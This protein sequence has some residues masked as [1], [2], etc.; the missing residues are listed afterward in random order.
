MKLVKV[1]LSHTVDFGAPVGVTSDVNL[2]RNP[3]AKADQVKF[4]EQDNGDVLMAVVGS[5]RKQ[6]YRIHATAII[7][8]VYEGEMPAPVPISDEIGTFMVSPGK[9]DKRTK[10]YRDAPKGEGQS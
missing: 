3:D 6:F 4:V 10:A 9:V 7:A 1:K 2:R 8:K 5:P